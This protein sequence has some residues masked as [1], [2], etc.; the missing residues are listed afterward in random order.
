M[1]FVKQQ[2]DTDCFR[3]CLASILERPLEAV[4]HFYEDAKD[5][6]HGKWNMNSAIEEWIDSWLIQ[7][8]PYHRIRSYWTAETMTEV[9]E[10]LS[11]NASLPYILSGLEPSGGEGH[12]VVVT[13]SQV[14]D[15]A[16][17]A[18]RGEMLLPFE[19]NAWMAE[20]IVRGVR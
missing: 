5:D 9:I 11:Y 19:D 6:Q 20:Y 13:P 7:N 4:P 12:C 16:M 2:T 8:G 1:K 10:L 18:H 15:P 14:F 3:A 17:K